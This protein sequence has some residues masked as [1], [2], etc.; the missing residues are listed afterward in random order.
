MVRRSGVAVAA[1]AVIMSG[2]LCGCGGAASGTSGAVPITP[3]CAWPIA[4]NAQ[5]ISE[6]PLLNISNPDIAADY[7]VMAFTV[8]EGLRI[9]LSGHYPASRYVSFAVYNS[10]GTPFTTDGVDSIL[11]DYRIAPDPGSLNPWQHPGSPGGRFT[12]TLRADVTAGQVNTLPLAPPG[13]PAGTVGALFLRI[14]ASAQANPGTISLP[15]VTFAANGVSKT[16]TACPATAFPSGAAVLQV[17]QVLGLPASYMDSGLPA[18]ADPP[19]KPGAPG[20]IIPFAAYPVGAGG[21]VDP[22]IAYLSA[23]AVPP[24][25]GDVLVIRAKAPTTPSGTL[26]TPWPA[27]GDELRY[28]S[29]CDDLKP[30]PTPVVVNHLPDGTVDDGCRYDS[31]VT[32]DQNGYY[33]IVVGTETQRAAIERIPGATFLP[34]AAAEPTQLHKLNIRN[35]LPN[36]DF[37]DAIQNVPADGSPSSAAAVMGPYYPQAAFCSLATLAN[38]GPNACVPGMT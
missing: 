36:P 6:N 9:T 5:T 26:P 20:T 4:T 37:H 24:H 2:L 17:L 38:S 11:T 12:V 35:M 33:T 32:L 15:T 25:N 10:H 30:S 19:A 21:T 1:A 7:W 8:Q 28:W 14:Y 34:F 29:M 23:F 18:T 16:L 3:D 22:D 27:P 13:T 31:Q